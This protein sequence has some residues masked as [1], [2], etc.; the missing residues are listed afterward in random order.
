MQHGLGNL[1][2]G[3]E[4]PTVRR[5]LILVTKVLQNLANN[6][7]FGSKELFMTPVNGFLDDNAAGI[8]DY[9]DGFAV[10]CRAA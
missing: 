3:L 5:V 10:R 7:H 9:L 8:A 4:D 2:A 6:V 1:I